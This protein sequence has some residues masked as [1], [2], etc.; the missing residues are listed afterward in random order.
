[1]PSWRPCEPLDS[2]ALA[3]D[4]VAPI[5]FDGDFGRR[6][7]RLWGEAQVA[8][9]K[10]EGIHNVEMTS[11]PAFRSAVEAGLRKR[12]METGLESYPALILRDAL[13]ALHKLPASDVA[14]RIKNLD[15]SVKSRRGALLVRQN[16]WKLAGEIATTFNG[17][18][19]RPQGGRWSPRVVVIAALYCY[20]EDLIS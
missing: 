14:R 15:L 11:A 9:S 16:C 19:G 8:R 3:R 18:G 1:V 12:R 20:C 6:G 2:A 13:V 10:G 17:E 7:L 5:V 4:H